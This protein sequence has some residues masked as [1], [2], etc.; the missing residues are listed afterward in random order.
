MFNAWETDF[1]N[2]PFL[3]LSE[4]LREELTQYPGAIE[5]KVIEK[6]RGA[7][8]RVLET[9]GP[10][11]IRVLASTLLGSAGGEVAD[12]ILRDISDKDVS[13]Y[14]LAKIAVNDFREALQETAGAFEG[15]PL[16]VVIDEL[17]RCRPSYAAELL[18]VLKHMFAVDGV[19]FILALNRNERVH[20]DRALYG[21]EFDAAVYLRRFID[22][23]VRLPNADRREF[24]DARLCAI[25]SQLLRV[26]ADKA[27]ARDIKGIALDW[28]QRFFGTSEVDLRT[29]E[30]ALHR[31]G[32][33]LAT[34]QVNYDALV[35]STAF[36]MI[37]RT[38]EPDLYY[39]FVDRKATDREVA[40]ALFVRTG[41]EYRYENEGRNLEAEIIM[42]A[43]EDELFAGRYNLGSTSSQLLTKYFA[44][45]N[46][47]ASRDSATDTAN[48]HAAAIVEFVKFEYGS[49]LHSSGVRRFRDAVSRLEMFSN[50]LGRE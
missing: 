17:D 8:H 33:M 39:R 12:R 30:Q 18:E 5:D 19:V 31:F 25:R 4:E 32:L 11:T 41:Q 44:L 40:D 49:R 45:V 46:S 6:F 16:V 7:A 43:A 23:D 20:S 24:I 35:K 13:Q 26:L 2:D 47:P 3:A 38:I 50:D 14:S 10:T 27:D 36:V 42:A 28:L 29:V 15:K 48:E 1:A 9:V 21:V 34:L 22:I 37:L